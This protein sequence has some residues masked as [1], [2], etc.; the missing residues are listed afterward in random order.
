MPS[1]EAPNR[2]LAPAIA[3]RVVPEL[4]GAGCSLIELI[5][6]HSKLGA[7]VGGKWGETL[8]EAVVCSAVLRE[9]CLDGCGLRG[10]LPELRLP[11]LQELGLVGNLLSGGLEPLQGCT[12][13]RRLRLSHNKFTGTLEPLRGCTALH[14]LRLDSNEPTGAG[15]SLSEAA[16]CCGIRR[17]EDHEVY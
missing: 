11:A 1:I 12:G 3:R 15:S 6:A 8:G 2:A 7:A 4:L 13:L 10:P 5:L 14:T 17:I 16:L 9:L